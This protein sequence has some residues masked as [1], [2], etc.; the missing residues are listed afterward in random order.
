MLQGSYLWS[1]IGPIPVCPCL[2]DHRVQDWTQHSR[3]GLN[4]LGRGWITSN[5]LLKMLFQIYLRMLLTSLMQRHIVVSLFIHCLPWPPG[6]LCKTAFQAF[7][8]HPVLVHGVFLLQCRAWHFPWM[9]SMGFAFA[10]VFSLLKSLWI[11]AQPSGL[12]ITPP[13]F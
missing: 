8:R 11:G 4:C 7:S 2:L 9:N 10:H 3:C 5:S 12:S 1:F 6:L 13:S